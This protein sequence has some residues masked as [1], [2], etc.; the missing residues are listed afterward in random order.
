MPAPLIAK[1]FAG[2]IMP[3]VLDKIGEKIQRLID[4]L[5]WRRPKPPP[6]DPTPHPTGPDPANPR[7]GRV[8]LWKPVSESDGRCVVLLGSIFTGWTDKRLILTTPAETEQASYRST[9][10]PDPGGEREHYRFRRAGAGYTGPCTLMIVAKGHSWEWT[11]S[12]PAKRHDCNITPKVEK[13]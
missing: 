9:G 3:K 12:D 2:M 7:S 5:P 4:R 13:L 8:M 10:N 6:A 11:F 1:G